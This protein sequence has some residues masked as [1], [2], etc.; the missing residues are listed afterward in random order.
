M[1]THLKRALFSNAFMKFAACSLL[2]TC[3][4]PVVMVA[5]S[6][7]ADYVESILQSK[8]IIGT[9]LDSRGESIIGANVMEVGTSNG[10]ITDLEGNFVLNVSSNAKISISYIGY[11]TKELSVNEIKG[12]QVEITLVEDSKLIDEVVIIGYGTQKKGDVTSSVASVK[13]DD[14][15]K[16]AARDAGSLIQGK[17]AG[18]SISTP[19]GDPTGGTQIML[20]GITT[21]KSGTSPLVLIDGIPGSLTTVSPEDIESIDVLKDGSAAAIYGS[22]GTNGVILITTKKVKG[23]MAPTIEYSGYVSVQSIYKKADMLTAEDIRRL[24]KEDTP[25]IE[26]LGYE[27]DW[28]DAISRTPVSHTHNISL[29]GGTSKTNYIVNVNYRDMQGLFLGSDKSALN[30]RADVNHSMFNDKLRINANLISSETN[31]YGFNGWVYRQSVIRNPTDRI[32]DDEGNYQER[33]LFQYENPVAAINEKDEKSQNRFIRWSTSIN[34]NPMK[35][36]NFKLLLSS[37]KSNDIYGYSTT[38]K[39]IASS[40]DGK[41]GEATRSAGASVTNMLEFTGDYKLSIDKHNIGF[42]GGYTYEDS[43]WESFD[44]YNFDFPSDLYS[45]NN[46]TMGNA[47]K[48]GEAT[49]NSYKAASKRAAFLARFTYNYADKYLLMA[50]VRHE[51]SSKFGD[52]H[53]WG[54]FP[55]MSLGW[56][57]NKESFLEDVSWID[58]LKLRVGF[59]VTGTEPSDPYM[60][61][62]RLAY[63]GNVFVD[64]KWVNQIVP[65]SNPNPDLKWERKHEWNFGL[66]YSFLNGRINGTL[67]YYVRRTKDMLWDY[68]VPTPP[69]LYGSILANVGEMENKGFEF[70]LN[71]IPVSTRDFQWQTSVN[72]STNKNKLLTLSNDKFTTT[73]T[74]FDWGGTGDPIQQATHRID[75]GG[76]IGNFYGYKSIDIDENGEWIL[77]GKDG[78]PVKYKDRTPDDKQYIG[79]GLPKW[80]AGWNNSFRYKNW[81]LNITMRGAFGFQ[82]LNSQRMFYENPNIPYNRLKSA[83]D[84]VYGKSL[85]TVGQEYVSYYI[86][87]GDYWKIDNVTLGY[88]FDTKKISWLKSARLYFSGLNLLTITGYK[89]MD[90]EVNRS[91]LDPGV[92]NRDKYPTTR[93]FTF[94]VNLTF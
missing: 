39:H 49:M 25:Y 79:N 17:V 28:F 68:Q 16:G 92:D 7:E 58:D 46:M 66:D 73:N 56:R 82:I 60:S 12:G 52:N 67:D 37:R 9:V 34:L 44:M 22:Q 10:T 94:G 59:G 36:L 2:V 8:K 3:C 81:D 63:S 31:S 38:F 87:D 35:G 18:L 27:T 43:E 15:I 74:Y 65:A 40:R 51:G 50:S 23:E 48:R 1:N 19:S 32:Y 26:D 72:F 88:T 84:K 55:A 64:G 45:Y 20:R 85:L 11:K 90:P 86:E 76:P 47:L 6:F 75:I 62:T 33:S 93:T 69:Y 53:K 80:Y 14:F 5:S 30:V 4:S 71:V 21:L 70:L 24:A 13:S 29:K 77:E 91:G 57:I 83:F 41:N 61:L 54:T 42:I 78:Q 89:G